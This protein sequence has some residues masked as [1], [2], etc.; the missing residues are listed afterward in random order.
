MTQTIDNLNKSIMHRYSTKHFDPSNVVTA[1]ELQAIKNL[2]RFSPSSTNAQPW[3]FIIATTKEAKE[4]VAKGTQGANSFNEY[5]I[6]DAAAVIVLC[7]KTYMDKAH[8]DHVL[9]KE[10]KDG[11]FGDA[12]NMAAQD[13]GRTYFANIHRF[14]LKDEKGWMEKQVYLSM[15]FL[16]MGLAEMGLD[17]VPLEGFDP[18]ALDAE[19]GLREQGYT[20]VGIVPIGHRAETDGNASRPKSRLTE[21]EIFTIL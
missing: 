15:G 17:S 8:L 7:S 18:N 21:E 10:N 14:E 12:E 4:R 6:M 20:S 13:A 19:F 11:R 16:L 1:E 9:D 5:K 3:H 2:L